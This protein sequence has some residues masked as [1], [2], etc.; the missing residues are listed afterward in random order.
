MYGGRKGERGRESNVQ[1][2]ADIFTFTSTAQAQFGRLRFGRSHLLLGSLRESVFVVRWHLCMALL[3][4]EWKELSY[5]LLIDD[6]SISSG[7]QLAIGVVLGLHF[8]LISLKA[9]RLGLFWLL[10]R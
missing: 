1:A 2:T 6:S 9:V 8:V 4:K 3:E 5:R 7:L 10:S